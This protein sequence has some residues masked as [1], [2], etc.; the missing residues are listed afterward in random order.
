MFSELKNICAET[1]LDFSDEHTALAGKMHGFGVTVTDSGDI[2]EVK[3]FCVRPFECETEVTALIS[4]LGEH[5]PKNTLMKQSCEARFVCAELAKCNLLQEN[6][7][8]LIGFIDGLTSGISAL[9]IQ[10]GEPSLP[11]IKRVSAST[12]ATKRG[13]IKLG[14]DARSLIGL[15]GAVVGAAAMAVIAVLIVN[16]K[17]EIDTFGL[18][19]EVSGYILS[20][21][22]VAVVFADYRFLARKLDACGVIACPVLSLISVVFAG[23]GSGVKACSQLEGSTFMQVL[24]ELPQYLASHTEIES[25]VVGYITR[26]ILLAVLA[27]IGICIFYFNRHPDEMILTEKTVSDDSKKAD[28]N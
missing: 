13:K 11:V 17:L 24:R 12:A 9:G 1:G 16:V 14:F 4:A 2:Y 18:A 22:T 26:G 19:F 6:I 7:V 25:F 3:V 5:L 21:S 10:A 15:L 27:S 8:H 23:I 20:G 28:K